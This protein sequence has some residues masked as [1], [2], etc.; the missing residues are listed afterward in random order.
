MEALPGGYLLIQGEL[1]SQERP[2]LLE[3]VHARNPTNPSL[4]GI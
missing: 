2:E 1:Q 4:Q 3:D